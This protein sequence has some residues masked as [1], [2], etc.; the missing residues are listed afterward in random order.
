[1]SDGRDLRRQGDLAG[2]AAA[3]AAATESYRGRGD[4]EGLVESLCDLAETLNML[5]DPRRAAARAEEAVEALRRNAMLGEG[6]VP[7]PLAARALLALGTSEINAGDAATGNLDAAVETSR[8]VAAALPTAANRALLA[9]A[10]NSRSA[11]AR[12]VGRPDDAVAA[13]GEAVAIRRELS[14]T[15]PRQFEGP[16]GSSLNNLAAAQSAQGDMAAAASSAMEA[17][18]VLRGCA[19]AG[20]RAAAVNLAAAESNAAAFLGDLGEL[21][22]AVQFGTRAVEGYQ[23]L[24]REQPPPAFVPELAKAL[25]VLATCL[26]GQDRFE[27]AA[28]LCRAATAVLVEHAGLLPAPARML[29]PSA[30]QH[31]TT[32]AGL[33]GTDVDRDLLAAAGEA[34]SL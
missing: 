32:F 11:Q 25:I 1:V 16:L 18:S 14:A 29:I 19:E 7:N 4:V 15:D 33:G 12:A 27:Q 34:L 2:A 31:Y 24:V 28:G 3:F 6:A 9:I 21:E 8:C 23:Q 17:S 13:A 10:L 20:D 22:L 5:G 30:M 26:A